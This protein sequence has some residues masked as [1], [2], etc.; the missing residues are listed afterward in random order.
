MI[1]Q[2]FVFVFNLFDKNSKVLI[3]HFISTTFYQ[4]A[5][6]AQFNL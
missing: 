1:N 6:C 5:N 2:N 3:L 4:K